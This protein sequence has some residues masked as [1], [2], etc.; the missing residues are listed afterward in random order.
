MT[1]VVPPAWVERH[2]IDC[3]TLRTV[4]KVSQPSLD[5][6]SSEEVIQCSRIDFICLNREP[7][8]LL[9]SCDHFVSY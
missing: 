8:N 4:G 6:R 1:L 7:V 9:F 5:L 2:L 3:D